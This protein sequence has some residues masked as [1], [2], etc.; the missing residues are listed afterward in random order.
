[1]STNKVIFILIVISVGMLTI[2]AEPT[3]AW[4]ST[5]A[6]T[7]LDEKLGNAEQ[8]LRGENVPLNSPIGNT[9]TIRNDIGLEEEESAVAYSIDRQQYL[10]VWYNDRP[11]NDDIRA[12]RVSKNGTLVGGAFYISA[13]AGAERRYPDVT[14][15]SKHDQYLVVWEHNDGLWNSIRARRVS[16]AGVVLDTTDIVITSGS[17]IITPAQ[18]AVEYAFTSDRYLAVWQDTFHPIPIQFDIMG[19]VVTSSGTPDGSSFVISKDPGGKRRSEPDLAYNRARNEYLVA[20]QQD[21]GGN[22]IY[23]R[24]VTG[25][26]TPLNPASIKIGDSLRPG[27][28]PAVAAIPKPPGQGQYLVVWEAEWVPTDR[29]IHGRFVQGDGNAGSNLVIAHSTQDEL[30]PTV[31]GS[32]IANQYLVAWSLPT[33]PPIV[34]YYIE[35]SMIYPNGDTGASKYIAGFPSAA[36]PAVASGPSGDFLVTFDDKLPPATDLGIYGQLWGNR[37]YLPL[38]VR[39]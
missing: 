28:S 1:M 9:I 30:K 15:N 14:Y 6:T 11:G 13:G 29:D 35:G 8:E 38:T 34:Y 12:Q 10:V 24:R 39:K 26:G 33:P 2:G 25:A 16:G 22:I 7:P 27:T 37:I 21:E 4:L 23:A 36:R 19:R 5:R 20:W 32:E 3:R 18:P 17:N 31:A